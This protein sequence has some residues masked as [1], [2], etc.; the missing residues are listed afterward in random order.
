MKITS[1]GFNGIDESQPIQ[2]F[3]KSASHM[4]NF[5][6]G[7]DGSLIKRN[8]RVKV[9]EIDGDIDSIWSGNINGEEAV[10]FAS[11]GKLYRISS[12][13]IPAVPTLI[14]DIGEEGECLMFDFNG[15]LYIKSESFYGKYDGNTISEVEGYIPCVAMSC[16]PSGEGV[17]LEQINILSDKRRQLFSGTGTGVFYKLAENEIDEIISIKIDGVD[18][19]YKYSLESARGAISFEKPPAE[20]LNNVE[21]IYSKANPESDRRRF[22][23]CTRV[24]LFG[25]NSD[26][27][28]FFWGNGEYPN[29]RFHTELADGIPSVEYF[30]INAFTVIGNSRIN[31][32]VQQYDRQLIFT[33]NQA[34]YSYCELKTDAL[35]NTYSSFPVFSLNGSKGCIIETDGCIIDNRPITLCND[36]LNMW[37]STSV[38]NEKNAVCFTMAINDTISG[39]IDGKSDI[40]IFDF[41]ANRELYLISRA[42]A[43]VYNYNIGAWYKFDGF[44]GKNFTALGRK[45][46][47]AI[48]NKIYAYGQG[49]G[50]Y[51]EN[52]CLWESNFIDNGSI[53]GF[54]DVMKVEADVRVSGAVN[55]VVGIKTYDG[56]KISSSAFIFPEST[57]RFTRI[58]FRPAIKRCMPYS[59]FIEA[60][61]EGELTVNKLTVTTREKERSERREIL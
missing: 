36:G 53:G 59:I 24:M 31:S 20:G 47:F 35:G 56:D 43:Y 60:Y 61:G 42:A 1:K 46:Y 28:A 22:F 13:A 10:I 4:M 54:C 15:K 33:E 29:Y 48:G 25:G 19:E 39:L 18:Y 12:T 30:P 3:P 55:L 49:I 27:R 58:S 32:I 37:E 40:S 44:G 6:I 8:G 50:R 26:G 41:Q 34:F 16:S 9:S 5:R 21:I 11:K 23:G 17:I 51:S 2:N 52:E 38:E 45:L 7:R 57:E 14:G